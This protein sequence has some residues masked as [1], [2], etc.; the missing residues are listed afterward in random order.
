MLHGA[1]MLTTYMRYQRTPPH[2]FQKYMIQVIALLVNNPLLKRALSF[3]E[4]RTERFHLL[5]IW[6]QY[7]LFIAMSYCKALCA[8]IYFQTIFSSTNLENPPH[9]FI[10]VTISLKVK[11]SVQQGE[12]LQRYSMWKISLSLC[13]SNPW[14][15]ECLLCLKSTPQ[16]C[17]IHSWSCPGTFSD[18]HRESNLGPLG[19]QPSPLTTRLSETS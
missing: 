16:Q 5:Q 11:V 15:N 2:Y 12:I 4:L 8:L 17:R 9:D 13:R 19:W 1:R 3:S 14:P 7:L 6:S 18:P 10:F